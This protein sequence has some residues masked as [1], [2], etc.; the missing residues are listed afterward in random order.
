MS[1]KSVELSD[2]GVGACVSS[3][4][5]LDDEALRKPD[6]AGQGIERIEDVGLETAITRCDWVAERLRRSPSEK[7]Q[8]AEQCKCDAP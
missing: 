5:T 6:A 1:N 2:V 4:L 7:P 8:S 3:S